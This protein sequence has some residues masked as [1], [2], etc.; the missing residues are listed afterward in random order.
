M[1][2]IGH[3]IFANNAAI[4]EVA[5]VELEAWGCGADGQL[6]SRLGL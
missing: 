3:T 1:Q 5:A 2:L 6:S 4:Q